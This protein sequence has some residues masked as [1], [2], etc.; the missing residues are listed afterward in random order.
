MGHIKKS[1]FKLKREKKN[2][3]DNNEKKDHNQ[4]DQV[5]AATEELVIVCYDNNVNFACNETSWVIDSGPLLHLTSKKEFFT[6]YT[7]KNFGTLKMGNDG[8]AEVVG[9]GDVCLEVSN[10]TRLVLRDVRHVPDIRLNLI[11]TGKLDD[12]RFC[13]TFNNG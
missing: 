4:D 2:G 13:N 12:E 11:S 7:P 9:V 6:S 8:L 5:A 10:G 1:C 3:S